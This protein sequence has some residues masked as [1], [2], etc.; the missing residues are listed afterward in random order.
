MNRKIYELLKQ[1]FELTEGR[2]YLIA[3]FDNGNTQLVIAG[4]MLGLIDS[5][6]KAIQRIS[7]VTGMTWNETYGAVYSMQKVGYSNIKAAFGEKPKK[8]VAGS[9]FQEQLREE[10]ERKAD[11][12]NMALQTRLDLL[13]KELARAETINSRL[14]ENHEKALAVKDKQ[15]AELTKELKREQ[16]RCD[17]CMFRKGQNED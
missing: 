12:K 4:D 5:I 2:A 15:I 1:D 6:G 3:D 17:T 8:V 9:D 7:E 11:A 13:A 16:H 14:K 10:A